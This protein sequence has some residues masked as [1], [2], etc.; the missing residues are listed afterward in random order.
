[1]FKIKSHTCL[2]A[3]AQ[4]HT[5]M[6]TQSHPLQEFSTL[7]FSH[8]FF[9]HELLTRSLNFLSS[10]TH[11]IEVTRKFPKLYSSTK[12]HC[13]LHPENLTPQ[14]MSVASIQIVPSLSFL[15]CLTLC[16]TQVY[17]KSTPNL[18]MTFSSFPRVERY[19]TF[20]LQTDPQ[21]WSCLLLAPYSRAHQHSASI[22]LLLQHML[23]VSLPAHELGLDYSFTQ[24]QVWVLSV[25]ETLV[26]Q[27]ELS[28]TPHLYCSL[29]PTAPDLIVNAVW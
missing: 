24:C 28:S 2:C 3:Q 14:Q 11:H 5:C 4:M 19:H 9:S 25:R 8:F 18:S 27:G 16:S 1:M 21:Y 17:A 20:L 13:W 22:G 15:L 10:E 26:P 23:Q 12:K 6:G 7:I 29:L